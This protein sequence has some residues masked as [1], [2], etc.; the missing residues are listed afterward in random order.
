MTPVQAWAHSFGASRLGGFCAQTPESRLAS[1]G[2]NLGPQVFSSVQP[3][4]L[5][6]YLLGTAILS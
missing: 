5:L 2:R 6:P 3:V 4:I 1:V